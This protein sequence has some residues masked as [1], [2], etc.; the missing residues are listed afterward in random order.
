[1]TGGALGKRLSSVAELVRQG[2][3]F[4]DIGTDH[5]YLPIFL[6]K[7]GIIHRAVCSDINP[8][9]LESARRNAAS[10][11]LTDRMEFVLCDGAGALW[12]KGITDYAVCGMGGE[13]IADIIEAAPHLRSPDIQLILQPMTRQSV[14]RRYLFSHG[15]SVVAESYSS[16]DSRHYVTMLVRYTGAAR[17]LTDLEAEI[18]TDPMNYV[19][20]TS[21]IAYLEGKIAALNKV[22]D[23]KIQGGKDAFGERE[24][25]SKIKSAADE[26]RS[27]IK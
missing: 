1:M 3:V 21:Q 8:G 4:A 14:L 11:G 26:I 9:P 13:L 6:L 5:A 20:K 16:E 19:N 24:L 18:G 17:M 10:A 12:D 23:G 22:I 2:A 7:E 25:L 27:V 15:F